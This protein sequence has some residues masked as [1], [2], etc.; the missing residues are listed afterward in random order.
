MVD[1]CVAAAIKLSHVLLGIYVSIIILLAILFLTP[2]PGFSPAN[3]CS[4]PTRIG[5]PATFYSHVETYD[6]QS[7]TCREAYDFSLL[8]LLADFAFWFVISLL[9]ILLISSSMKRPSAVLHQ[10]K[11]E[12]QKKIQ[13]SANLLTPPQELFAYIFHI[14]AILIAVTIAGSR[15]PLR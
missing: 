12:K 14:A 4:M 1:M 7:S 3:P 9:V 13:G 10:T 2:I 11:I 5:I 15:D 6:A 8:G